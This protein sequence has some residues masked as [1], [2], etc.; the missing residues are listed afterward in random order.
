ML[1]LWFSSDLNQSRATLL[2]ES[3]DAKPLRTL[4]HG[5]ILFKTPSNSIHFCNETNSLSEIFNIH[6]NYSVYP[7][8]INAH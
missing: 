2:F 6:Q 1:F 8:T 4:V 3:S 7:S 5:V